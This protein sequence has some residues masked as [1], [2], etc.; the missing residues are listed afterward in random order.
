[1]VCNTIV[2]YSMG[3]LLVF[4]LP[5]LFVTLCPQWTSLY[6]TNMVAYTT[7]AITG[8]LAWD[9]HDCKQC[10]RVQAIQVEASL[11]HK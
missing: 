10:R 1:M 2:R 7:L 3:L 8:W 11:H 5:F 6:Q 4:G 9:I